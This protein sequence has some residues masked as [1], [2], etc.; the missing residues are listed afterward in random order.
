MAKRPCAITLTPDEK[1][2]ICA[3]RFGDV[4]SLPLDWNHEE[5]PAERNKAAKPRSSERRQRLAADLSTVHTKGNIQALKNQQNMKG[6]AEPKEPV[7][8]FEHEHLLG[9]VSMLTDVAMAEIATSCGKRRYIFTADRDEHIR[10]SRGPPQSYVIERFLLEHEELVNKLHIPCWDPTKLV[11]GGGD[12]YL[13]VWDWGEGKVLQKL[14]VKSTLESSVGPNN[15]EKIVM[16]G[17]W[18]KN[19]NS[20]QNI[21]ISCEA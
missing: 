19:C 11:S 1:S 21:F 4:Y 5:R 12:D 20:S 18:S 3:D 6:K 7:M 13:L 17:I 9:H 2:I 14:D 8:D 10:M 16:T 15:P